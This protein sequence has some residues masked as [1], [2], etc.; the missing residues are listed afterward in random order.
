MINRKQALKV[1]NSPRYEDLV[2]DKYSV[3]IPILENGGII[4]ENIS[5]LL[6]EEYTLVDHKYP[7]YL[8]KK[9]IIKDKDVVCDEYLRFIQII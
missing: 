8:D 2:S 3:A 4:I 7:E 9:I 1:Y 6:S 5:T